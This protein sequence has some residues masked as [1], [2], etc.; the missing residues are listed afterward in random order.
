MHQ[1]LTEISCS[2]GNSTEEEL[3][4][5][6]GPVLPTSFVQAHGAVCPSHYRVN[7]DVDLFLFYHP[8]LDSSRRNIC[9]EASATVHGNREFLSASAMTISANIE[10][11][12]WS[13]ENTY[14]W[15]T[16]V[17]KFWIASNKSLLLSSNFLQAGL[18]IISSKRRWHTESS[19]TTD[20]EIH[21]EKSKNH[22]KDLSF[23]AAV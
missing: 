22:K 16:Y 13:C 10:L 3:K 2:M 15:N 21:L 23:P 8:S 5:K 6:N 19:Y 9:P 1:I 17:C 11:K 18:K 12:Q 7:I 4:K 14:V 20:L